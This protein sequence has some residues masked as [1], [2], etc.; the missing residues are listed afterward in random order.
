[1]SSLCKFAETKGNSKLSVLDFAMTQLNKFE[2]MGLELPE[3]TECLSSVLGKGPNYLEKLY[4]LSER[5]ARD[6]NRFTFCAC[7]NY[8]TQI[9]IIILTSITHTVRKSLANLR[10]NENHEN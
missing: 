8:V 9:T 2:K 5:E 10:S 3:E 4:V 6:Y 1:M 7:F